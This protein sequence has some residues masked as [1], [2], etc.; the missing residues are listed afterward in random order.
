M[1]KYE[2]MAIFDPNLQDDGIKKQIKKFEGV[3]EGSKGQNLVTNH[4]GRKDIA[5]T[6][7]KFRNG[8]FVYFTYESDNSEIVEAFQ[9]QLGL[10]ES[11]IKYQTHRLNLPRR[12]FRGK[13]GA[14]GSLHQI[15]E[16]YGDDSDA[17]Y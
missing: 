2:T 16:E 13:P 9:K 4:M 7:G 5:Y 6:V 3:L 1:R 11:V 14:K 17:R 8:H 15:L 12:K 10:D